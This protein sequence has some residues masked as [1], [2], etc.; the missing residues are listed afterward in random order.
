MNSPGSS[1]GRRHHQPDDRAGIRP[2][3]EAGE[4]R[5]LERQIGGV[6]TQQNAGRH[7]RGQRNAQ[8]EG[9]QQ[10][11]GPRAPLGDQNVTEPVIA[12]EDRG[13]GRDDR[14]LDDQRRQQKLI[15]REE[16]RLWH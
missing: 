2:G 8:A 5:A 10:P 15:G 14:D 13:K 1:A 6:V 9:E 3:D 7:A 16:F 11:F 12:D 4:K